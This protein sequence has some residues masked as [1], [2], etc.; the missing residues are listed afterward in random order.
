[1]S[2]KMT[3]N[4]EQKAEVFAR[5]IR[6]SG[7]LFMIA[8]N[9]LD[10]EC[11][12]EGKMAIRQWMRR[13]GLWRGRQTR[14]GHQAIG[15]DINMENMMKHWDSAAAVT[16]SL[17][18]S[19]SS[20]N[21]H[22]HPRHVQITTTDEPGNCPQSVLWR[23]HNFWL[24][25]HVM[26][27]E[28][29]VMYARGYHQDAICVIPENMM[30]NDPAC[31]FT[32]MIPTDAIEPEIVPLY[33]NEDIL[34][35]WQSEPVWEAQQSSLRRKS[36]ITAARVSFLLE[37]LFEKFP[38]RAEELLLKIL[39]QWFESRGRDLRDYF[40]EKGLGTSSEEIINNFEHPYYWLWDLEMERNGN[41]LTF[42]VGYCPFAETWNWL[43]KDSLLVLQRNYCKKCYNGVFSQVD[44]G[45]TAELR[46]CKLSGDAKCKIVL[47]DLR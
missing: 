2:N 45:L 1:M 21:S 33:E 4:D 17:S 46:A 11:G 40:K 37:V 29:H 14:K 8:S 13:W 34:K 16:E 19:W 3:M 42:E 22:W 30:K 44:Q 41:E 38:E 10:E 31:K 47:K 26:C 9:V 39:D 24:G 32:F 12:L 15:L 25:G 18:N 28:F 35:D 36:R 43:S 27:D 6:A 20:E 23:E 5:H 7:W